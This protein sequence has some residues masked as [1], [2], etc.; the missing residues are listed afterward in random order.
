[1]ATQPTSHPSRLPSAYD[2]NGRVCLVTGAGKGIGAG[3]ALCLAEAGAS[4]VVSDLVFH[5]AQQT[6]EKISEIGGVA[7]ACELDVTDEQ[8]WKKV[9]KLTVEAF[10]GLDVL[11]NNAGR[12]LAKPIVDTSL[13]ELR[14]VT[15]PN[16]EGVF[17]G[18]KSSIPYLADLGRRRNSTASI[19][20]ISSVAGLVGAAGCSVYCMSKGAV[21]LLTKSAAL[22]LASQRIRV[23]SMHPGIVD[24]DMG[25][26]AVAARAGDTSTDQMK[27]A[28]SVYPIGRL[29]VVSDVANGA[30]YLASEASSF[31]TGSEF[32]L[33]GGLTAK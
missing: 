11:V 31:M 32:V 7:F 28:V 6:A 10:G 29:G 24:T 1:M 15:G 25:M 3:I 33:D 9:L 26:L 19:I 22:E 14:Q 27:A 18:I 13:E 4:V 5:A 16:M 17:I 23:N 12:F 2:L 30:L 20:N 21:R 8:N